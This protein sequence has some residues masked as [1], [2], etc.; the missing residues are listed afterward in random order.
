MH[1]YPSQQRSCSYDSAYRGATMTGT[2]AIMSGSES[3]LKSA[4]ANVGPVSVAVDAWNKAFIVS[5]HLKWLNYYSQYI[6]KDIT[7]QKA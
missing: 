2:V 6:V 1:I 4:V 7:Y 5:I 3:D